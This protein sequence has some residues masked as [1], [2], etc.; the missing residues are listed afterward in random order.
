MGRF[1][2]PVD[3]KPLKILKPKIGQDDYVMGPFNPANFSRNRSNVV[4]S[5]YSWNI[6]LN[7]VTPSLP[8][9]FFLVVA[10]S[11]KRVDGFSRSIP[12]TTRL[13][14]RMCLLRVSVREKNCSRYQNPIKP[15]KLSVVRRF[16]AKRKKNWI[17][18]IFETISQ[19]NTKFHTTLK[20]AKAPSW[21]VL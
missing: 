13:H 19:I 1:W 7:C 2:P 10:Y 11:K 8:F 12:Q 18:N 9:P 14:P 3:L 5:P 20:T 16:Q 21:V 4:R 15:P 6:T 17:L